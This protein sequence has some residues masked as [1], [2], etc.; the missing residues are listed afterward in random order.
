[1]GRESELWCVS[2]PTKETQ[3][4]LQRNVVGRS[5]IN[6]IPIDVIVSFHP[7]GSCVMV[8]GWIFKTM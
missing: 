4:I 3:Q 8:S 2:V 1:M 7:E 6:T 5:V